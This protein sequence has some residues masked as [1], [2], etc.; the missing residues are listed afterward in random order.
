MKKTAL[1]EAELLEKVKKIA[2]THIAPQRQALISGA[3]KPSDIWAEFCKSGLA[4]LTVPTRLG[5]LGADYKTLSA[6]SYHL[7]KIGGVPGLTM[8][9]NSHWIFAKLQIEGNAPLA[10]Q[11]WLMPLLATG[12]AVLSV[13]ISEPGV[14]AHP[15]RMTTT[16]TR[17]GDQYILNGEK[18]FL[19]NG[20]LA[21]HF[22]VLAITGE[23]EG[24][25]AFSAFLVPADTAGATKTSGITMD[26][27]H[28]CPHGGLEL[29]DCAIPA[30]HLLG[31]EGKAF[32]AI[33]LTMRAIED[34]VGAAGIVGSMECLLKDLISNTKQVDSGQVGSL[35][36]QLKALKAMTETL[37]ALAD[38]TAADIDPI[39]ELYLGFRQHCQTSVECLENIR[40]SASL[41]DYPHI[42]LLAR[43]IFK[44][45]GIARTAHAA[46]LVKIGKARFTP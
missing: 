17:S 43:D 37:A 21:N 8:M 22:I 16:A 11:E 38:Q 3:E 18:A 12:D 32:E 28:P 1:Q 5:G 19:T 27:L 31:E 20:P 45:H 15:K 23:A 30:S 44:F 35:S 13:A 26:F 24:R 25:R 33:S 46:R 36:V 2:R 40:K 9:F 41:D 14:G 42:H 34:A 39:F 29:K 4:G 6:A 7:N 10:M